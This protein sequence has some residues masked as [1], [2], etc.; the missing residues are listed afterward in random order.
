MMRNHATIIGES[1]EP[2]GGVMAESTPT[3]EPKPAAVVDLERRRLAAALAGDGDAYA[4][5]VRPH[6]GVMF[7]VAARTARRHDLAEDA[8]Q[9]ALQLAWQRLANYRAGTSLRAWLLAIVSKRAWTLT[10]SEIRRRDREDGAGAPEQPADPEEQ[11]RAAQMAAR[12]EE[13]LRELP[14]K[15]RQAVILRLDGGL[16]HAEIAVA[17]DS[18]ERSV[19]VLVHLALK[20]LKAA[21]KAD[22]SEEAGR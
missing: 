22:A 18:T 11:M 10:R 4:A 8:V 20:Q 1:R 14:D 13:V 21:L 6:L 7:R 2:V 19:R 17:L 9:E 16:S 15:R 12:I 5:L 3:G